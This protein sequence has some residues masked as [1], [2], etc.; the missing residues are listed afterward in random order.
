MRESIG[1]VE[2][3]IAST[4][5]SADIELIHVHYISVD[6]LDVRRRLRVEVCVPKEL[7]QFILLALRK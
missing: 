2:D 1:R 6:S 4:S 7:S 3:D 5:I